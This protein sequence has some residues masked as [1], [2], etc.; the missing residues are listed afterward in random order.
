MLHELIVLELTGRYV[1]DML[2]ML[3]VEF[4]LLK[5]APLVVVE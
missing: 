2:C 3:W 4:E 1:V 5:I